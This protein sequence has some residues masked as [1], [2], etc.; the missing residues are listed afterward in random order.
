MKVLM[1]ATRQLDVVHERSALRRI[2]CT[3]G[4]LQIVD[5]RE[6]SF[7][8]IMKVAKLFT[9]S[10]NSTYELLEYRIA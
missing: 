1:L 3:S 8:R 10:F 4:D 7:N 6:N 5:T 9:K 2:P